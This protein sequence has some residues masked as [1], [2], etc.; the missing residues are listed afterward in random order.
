M[1]GSRPAT[2]SLL[3]LCLVLSVC[4]LSSA[5]NVTVSGFGFLGG[6]GDGLSATAG[7]F[8]AESFAPDGPSIIG[9]GTVGMPMS[10][11]FT[12]I[13]FSGP[14][15]TVV[16]I[17]SQTT[18]LLA[19]F[20]QCITGTFT[21]PASAVAAGT[22]TTSVSVVGQLMAFK[23]LGGPQD[24]LMAT[25]AFAGTG[26]VQLQLV[27]DGSGTFIIVSG[28]ASF[29]N[30]KGTLTVLPETSSLLLVGTGLVFFGTIAGRHY[31]FHRQ[32]GEEVQSKTS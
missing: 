4:L 32:A 30:I 31:R 25:L 12:A 20:I 14:D 19:G 3:V 1:S 6:T 8:F 23:D 9:F 22:F 18:D 24:P 27:D 11:S 10:L 2:F 28:G 15:N 13:P 21:V 29:D 16:T 26:T 17:G 5:N 7:I